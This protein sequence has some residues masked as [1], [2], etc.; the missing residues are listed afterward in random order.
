VDNNVMN[1]FS[2]LKVHKFYRVYLNNYQRHSCETVIIF[3]Q[4]S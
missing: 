4:A 1:S 2:N 3:L